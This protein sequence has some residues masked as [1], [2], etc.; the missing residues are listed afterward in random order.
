MESI[1]T[2]HAQ[3]KFE[4]IQTLYVL[5]NIVINLVLSWEKKSFSYYFFPVFLFEKS[6]CFKLT[7]PGKFLMFLK[8]Y[9]DE[10]CVISASNMFL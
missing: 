8:T 9:S 2:S 4:A 6:I 3:F 5:L 1:L 10:S 7:W